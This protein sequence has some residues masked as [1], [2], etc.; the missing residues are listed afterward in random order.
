MKTR[1][2]SNFISIAGK[3]IIGLFFSALISNFDV[4]PAL[5]KD[6][7]K[8]VWEN[9]TTAVTRTGDAGTTVTI[10]TRMDMTETVTRMKGVSITTT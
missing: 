6:D 7:H 1:S 9:M 5:G 8:K 10:I 3:L 2:R 4:A